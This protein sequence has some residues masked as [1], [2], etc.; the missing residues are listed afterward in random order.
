MG[1]QDVATLRSLVRRRG[2]TLCALRGNQ[3]FYG[4]E[5]PPSATVRRR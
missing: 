2:T 5:A 3:G 1:Y 4:S